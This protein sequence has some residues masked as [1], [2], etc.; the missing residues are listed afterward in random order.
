MTNMS[1]KS[2]EKYL[3]TSNI[4]KDKERPGVLARGTHY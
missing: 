1:H 2:I 4:E 3:S